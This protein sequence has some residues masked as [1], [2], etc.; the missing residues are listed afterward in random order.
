MRSVMDRFRTVVWSGIVAFVILAV[1]QGL[2]GS[3]AI[4]NLKTTPAIPWSVLIMTPVLWL[5][6]QYLGGKGWPQSTSEARRNYL[7]AKPVSG[8]VFAWVLVAG[9]LSVVALT[10]CWIVMFQLFKMPGNIVP[11][12]S[13]YP[14]PALVALLVMG[15]LAAPLS[16]EAAFRGYAQGML[17]RRFSGPVAIFISSA[18]FALAHLTQGFLFPK[19]F[20]YFLA[21]IAI[22]VPAY[23]TKSILPGIA[24]HIVADLTF[25]TLVWPHDTTRRLVA[26]GGADAWFWIH[27]AQAVVFTGLAIAALSRLKIATSNPEPTSLPRKLGIECTVPN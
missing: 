10:G 2:W 23:L 26:E 6:W 13:K 21:G 9:V 18:M 11:D 4:L 19:L 12:V 16:E 8:R 3:M 15:S 25:F 7:R 17:E 27:V 24:V 1:G 20:V 5:L 14:L 22:G